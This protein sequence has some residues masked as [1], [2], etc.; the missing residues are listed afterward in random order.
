MDLIVCVDDRMGM[1]FNGRRQ[2]RD[3]VVCEDIVKTVQGRTLGLDKRSFRLFDDMDIKLH[4]GFDGCDCCFLEFS[5]PTDFLGKPDHI[6]M[7]R[8]NRHYPAD[9]YFDLQMDGYMLKESTEF[10]GSSHEK[11]TKE[12]YGYEK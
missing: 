2:S 4:E 11:I 1:A 9:V 10:A 3:R 5:G 7:Y 12:V 8:W 6:I